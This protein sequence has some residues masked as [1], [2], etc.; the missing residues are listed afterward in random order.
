M[1]IA[2]LIFLI[3]NASLLGLFVLFLICNL[4]DTKTKQYKRCGVAEHEAN[5][6]RDVLNRRE[7]EFTEYQKRFPVKSKYKL[8]DIV[9]IKSKD[10]TY[11]GKITSVIYTQEQIEEGFKRTF[12]YTIDYQGRQITANE[13]ELYLEKH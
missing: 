8:G 11:N 6:L 4:N 2:L 7:R 9:F 13:S 10:F 3:L 12:C 1:N 5:T